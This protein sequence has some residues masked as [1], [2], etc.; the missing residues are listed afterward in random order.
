[1]PPAF[2]KPPK[3]RGGVVGAPAVATVR[4]DTVVHQTNATM[5]VRLFFFRPDEA[6]VDGRNE[7]RPTVR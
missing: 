1:V 2:Q 3:S 7:T 5:L 6:A 4:I